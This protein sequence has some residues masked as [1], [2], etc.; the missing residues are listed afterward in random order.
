MIIHSCGAIATIVMRDNR[1]VTDALNELLV[2]RR[3]KSG[4]SRE[5]APGL[6]YGLVLGKR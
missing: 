6:G 4:L 3:R 5:S 2:E 1:A